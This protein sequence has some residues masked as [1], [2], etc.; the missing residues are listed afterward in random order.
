MRY[1]RDIRKEFVTVQ[2]I[3]ESN[4]SSTPPSRN[5]RQPWGH[6]ITRGVAALT[7]LAAVMLATPST[8]VHATTVADAPVAATAWSGTAALPSSSTTN[9]PPVQQPIYDC[10]ATMVTRAVLQHLEADAYAQCDMSIDLFSFQWTWTDA[11]TGQVLFTASGSQSNTTFLSTSE[12]P[13]VGT[14][15]NHNITLCFTSV[16]AGY[17]MSGNNCSTLFD[18]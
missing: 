1:V 7:A 4:T 15:G 2:T 14:P 13:Y 18:Q 8:S 9:S 5:S 12:A 11:T 17:V 16:V 10:A 3:E 6:R